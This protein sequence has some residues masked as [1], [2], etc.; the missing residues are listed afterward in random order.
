MAFSGF[1]VVMR[2]I[3]GLF[4][5]FLGEVRGNITKGSKKRKLR[6]GLSQRGGDLYGLRGGCDW[7]SGLCIRGV[8]S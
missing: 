7:M 8:V 2:V 3:R 6:S 5:Y 4:L 1:Y